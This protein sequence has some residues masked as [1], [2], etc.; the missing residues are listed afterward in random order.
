MFAS[1]SVVRINTFC[2]RSNLP[3]Q[4]HYANDNTDLWRRLDNQSTC[5]DFA[6]EMESRGI[7]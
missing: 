4:L 2:P 6:Q 7:G 1:L 5:P 3:L